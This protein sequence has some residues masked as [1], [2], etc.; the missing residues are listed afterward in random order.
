M[1]ALNKKRNAELEQER[2]RAA[3]RQAEILHQS[4]EYD[5]AVSRAYYAIFHYA[6]A[7]LF[8]RGFETKSHSGLSSLFNL[9]FVRTGLLEKKFAAMLSNAQKAREE[10]DYEPEIPFTEEESAER[11]NDAKAFLE[12]IESVFKE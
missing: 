12:K 1:N 5:G 9:H 7:A 11:V 2:G 10:S 8:L 3:L 4:K 6:R